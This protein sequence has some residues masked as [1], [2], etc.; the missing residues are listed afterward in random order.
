MILSTWRNECQAKVVQG[1]YKAHT[2]N[3][4]MNVARLLA[5]WLFNGYKVTSLPRNVSKLCGKYEVQSTA[6]ALP[7]ETVQKLW[8]HADDFDKTL[9]ALALNC[10]F[11]AID[12]SNIDAANVDL[13]TGYLD[14]DR[15]KVEAHGGCHVRYKLW[16][17]TVEFLK[18][19]MQ[20]QGQ[21][22][23]TE[24][25]TSLVSADDDKSRID[26]MRLHFKRLCERDDVNVPTGSGG[27]SFS[28]LRDTSATWIEGQA[29]HRALKNLF[30]AHRDKT[31]A[32][33]Y[34]YGRMVST[35]DLDRLIDDLGRFYDLTLP[36][37]ENADGE[38]TVGAA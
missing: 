14:F 9:L 27:Y 35:R 4:A 10:G 28:N 21:A 29:K 20:A 36:K 31:M 16:P 12:I 23:V 13:A 5:G 11:Y 34:V 3:H 30:L 1:T 24:N 33:F 32:K 22:L 15:A 17:V 38:M 19:T 25:G 18:R 8:T 7:V 26:N 2:F 6:K 37:I